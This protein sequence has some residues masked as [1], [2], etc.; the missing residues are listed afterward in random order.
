MKEEWEYK[1]CGHC[2]YHRS[3]DQTGDLF[4]VNENSDHYGTETSYDT[5]CDDWSAK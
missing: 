1:D 2:L 4:C 3:D 5:T